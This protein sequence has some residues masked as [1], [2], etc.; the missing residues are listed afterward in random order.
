MTRQE[1]EKVAM[2]E[3]ILM[4]TEAAK[5]LHDKMIGL[6]LTVFSAELTNR[7]SRRL[8]GKP[9]GTFADKKVTEIK[10]DDIDEFIRKLIGQ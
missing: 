6:A 4:C 8:F 7:L 9:D 1:F 2:E 10:E 3:S 5:E